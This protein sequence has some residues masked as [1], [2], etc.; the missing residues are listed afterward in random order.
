MTRYFLHIKGTAQEAVDAL[1]SHGIDSFSP[2]VPHASF[3][4]N[5]SYSDTSVDA[6]F[7]ERVS[8]WYNETG[9]GVLPFPAG[10]LLHYSIVD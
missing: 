10:T 9:D 5:E 7:G 2:I 3:L 1:N 6:Y 8:R 4:S